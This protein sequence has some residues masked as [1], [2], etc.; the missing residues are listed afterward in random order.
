[1]SDVFLCKHCGYDTFTDEGVIFFAKIYFH[2]LKCKKCGNISLL[3]TKTKEIKDI[4][5]NFDINSN[6]IKQ[7]SN[8]NE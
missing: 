4:S 5:V 8:K 6:E 1:M 7:I 3:Q 2:G